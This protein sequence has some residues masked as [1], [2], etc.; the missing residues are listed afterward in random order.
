MT[1]ESQKRHC[2]CLE[3]PSTKSSQKTHQIPG[4][5][6]FCVC[7]CVCV[8]VHVC[9]C[10]SLSLMVCVCVCVCVVLRGSL[11]SAMC[12]KPLLTCVSVC[13]CLCVCVVVCVCVCV[14]GG[15]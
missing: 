11:T 12:S 13:V 2:K 4:E 14:C 8:C 3:I 1:Q 9:V 5:T 7:V 10:V 6:D 15:E